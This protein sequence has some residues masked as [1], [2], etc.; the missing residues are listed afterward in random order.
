MDLSR[1][2][3]VAPAGLRPQTTYT[4]AVKPAPMELARP[5]KPPEPARE[6][7][8]KPEPVGSKPDQPSMNA[9]Q[10]ST[11]MPPAQKNSSSNLIQRVM[12]DDNDGSGAD[13]NQSSGGS[14]LSSQINLADMAEKIL[15]IVKRML[16]IEAERSGRLFR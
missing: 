3:P 7:S 8:R 10:Q 14:E 2:F 9:P 5:P 15:P 1:M 13:D 16:Q 6:P 12:D 4:S 11:P